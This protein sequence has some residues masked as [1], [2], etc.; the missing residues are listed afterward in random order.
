MPLALGFKAHVA[1]L[2]I[3]VT[4]PCFNSFCLRRWS[5]KAAAGD[6]S[7][8]TPWSSLESSLPSSCVNSKRQ[9]LEIKS[10]E[11][12]FSSSHKQPFSSVW[13]ELGNAERSWARGKVNFDFRSLQPAW[14]SMFP[15]AFPTAHIKKKCSRL[16]CPS[17][18]SSTHHELPWASEDVLETSALSPYT[19]YLSSLCKLSPSNLFFDG[20]RV[21]VQGGLLFSLS[22]FIEGWSHTCSE[23]N[24]Q[25][26]QVDMATI[27]SENFKNREGTFG[28]TCA[29]PLAL[30]M[31]KLRL[32]LERFFCPKY[33][34]ANGGKKSECTHPNPSWLDFS[35][36]MTWPLIICLQNFL[37]PILN[38]TFSL[39]F[40]LS[41]VFSVIQVMR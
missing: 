13:R 22:Q 28:I 40:I 21:L 18:S 34:W 25:M 1:L 38:H 4:D 10:T 20:P 17:P 36:H 31:R 3:W 5:Q 9:H 27:Y 24:G 12:F 19:G 16:G 41:G 39:L 2:F 26:P 30:Q 11:S 29:K 23:K 8:L 35:H 15:S 7:R 33:Q 14:I 32:R 37:V 6:W